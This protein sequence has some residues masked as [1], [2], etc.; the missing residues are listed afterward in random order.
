MPV[1]C[2]SSRNTRMPP[3]RAV[4]PKPGGT[5]TSWRAPSPVWKTTPQGLLTST[6]LRTSSSRR[7]G[8]ARRPAWRSPPGPDRAVSR[9][10]T[11][12]VDR[13]VAHVP[14]ASV[15]AVHVGRVGVGVSAVHQFPV[16]GQ[17]WRCPCVSIHSCG[18]CGSELPQCISPAAHIGRGAAACSP[19]SSPSFPL[20]SYQCRSCMNWNSQHQKLI[21]SPTRLLLLHR[22]TP[23]CLVPHRVQ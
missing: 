17:S 12:V 16:P 9:R 18:G 14:A 7:R 11:S 20:L 3:S 13:P 1:T 19:D 15:G 23:N 5:Y 2:T 4:N 6:Q 22:T 10:D 21:W 8:L